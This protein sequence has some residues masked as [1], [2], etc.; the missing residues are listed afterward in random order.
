VLCSVIQYH[1]TVPMIMVELIS[2]RPSLACDGGVILKF[3]ARIALRTRICAPFDGGIC[4][5]VVVR[6]AVPTWLYTWRH[7]SRILIVV[8]L[9]SFMKWSIQASAA[10]KT[11]G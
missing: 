3:R 9:T 6:F 10:S 11:H 5:G 2:Y 4:Q 1:S 7:R 8:F